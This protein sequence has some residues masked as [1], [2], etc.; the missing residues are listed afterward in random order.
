MNRHELRPWPKDVK[1]TKQR[2]EIIKALNEAER[3]LSAQEISAEILKR[4]SPMWLSTVYRVLETLMKHG[5]IQKSAVNDSGTALYE[6]GDEHRHYAVCIDCKR[7]I[8]IMG[9]PIERFL[10]DLRAKSFHILGH[11]LQISG[12]CDDCYLKHERES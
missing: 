3:P 8:E 1:K 12:L 9:C 4:G 10:P 7:V 5:M 11:K 6:L 2:L